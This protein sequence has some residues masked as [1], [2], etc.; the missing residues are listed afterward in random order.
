MYKSWRQ[1]DVIRLTIAWRR[2]VRI[3]LRHTRC[4]YNCFGNSSVQRPSGL[5]FS[6][7][8]RN[9]AKVGRVVKAI[10]TVWSKCINKAPKGISVVDRCEGQSSTDELM[11]GASS[12]VNM[13][14]PIHNRIVFNDY[15][16][17]TSTESVDIYSSSTGGHKRGASIEWLH[18]VKGNR[19]V[20][21]LR[22]SVLKLLPSWFDCFYWHAEE[23]HWTERLISNEL[24]CSSTRNSL[25]I[26]Q[27][28]SISQ[29]I[30]YGC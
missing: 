4:G 1:V 10:I 18:F 17:R 15:Y 24:I 7:T 22:Q 14:F 16:D 2:H 23:L 12:D 9:I 20:C 29:G 11:L 27:R 21:K 8:W 30:G 5:G 28:S 25:S 19:D 3:P 26:L 13:G 6:P